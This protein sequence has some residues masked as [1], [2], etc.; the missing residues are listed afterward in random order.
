[1][2]MLRILLLISLMLS[3]A[4]AHSKTAGGDNT[5]LRIYLARHGQTDWNA[6]RRLQGQTDTE[7]NATGQQQAVLLRERLQGV[8]L[9]AIYTSA[10]RRSRDTA[11][12]VSEGKPIRSLA[13]L[14]ERHVGRFEG[15]TLGQ[16]AATD[17]EW[18]RRSK[19][20]SDTLDG[21]E[22]TTQMHA[23]VCSAVE[24]I[25][26]EHSGGSL[27]VVAHG[28]TNQMILRCLLNLSFERTSVIEQSNDELYLL[29]LK[30]G[31]E[32][33]V[34]KLIPGSKLGEL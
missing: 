14:N 7:L 32:T 6:T 4:C 28:G 22:S 30:K 5:T 15:V 26:S 27:L 18:S 2:K 33:K 9:D 1:M 19:L 13:A 23:R 8:P 10:L 31:L 16:D 24:Q 29:E 34:W 21:G 3:I 17:E 11:S 12:V 25:R 20:E